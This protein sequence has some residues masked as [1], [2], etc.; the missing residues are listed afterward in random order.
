MLMVTLRHEKLW[1]DE[2]KSG[3]NMIINVNDG[4]FSNWHKNVLS[5]SLIMST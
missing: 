5:V 2:S 4:I 3:G 1:Y